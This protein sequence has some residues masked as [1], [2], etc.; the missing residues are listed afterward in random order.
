MYRK[1]NKNQHC[2]DTGVLFQEHTGTGEE[3]LACNVYENPIKG[4]C[5]V[6][7]TQSCLYSRVAKV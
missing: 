6:E 4:V 3:R 2:D 7:D 1:T 5:I